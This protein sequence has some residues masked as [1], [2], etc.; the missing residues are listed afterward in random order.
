M[1]RIMKFATVS[2]AA[3]MAFASCDI[4]KHPVFDDKDAFVMITKSTISVEENANTVSIP[5]SMVAVNPVSVSVPY[6]IESGKAVEGVN[7]RLADPT[8][9]LTFDGKERSKDIVIEIID[10]AGSFD[11]DLDFTVVLGQPNGFNL[12]AQKTC[13]VTI[14]DLDHPLADILGTYT[15]SGFDGWDA[16]NVTWNMTINKVE[17]DVQAVS[18]NGLLGAIEGYSSGDQVGV[19]ND[20][21]DQI[22]IRLGGKFPWNSDYTGGI[23]GW[24]ESGNYGVSEGNL[25]LTYNKATKTWT[26]CEEDAEAQSLAIQLYNASDGSASDYWGAYIV[27][28]IT[29]TKQ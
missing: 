14:L 5:V 11:G 18:I 4:N 12:G 9:V 15:G 6:T 20:D 16:V 10:K 21:K 23:I 26:C 25:V 22:T 1:N 3:V 29:Y 2:V 24:N 28:P 13:K 27:G 7:Y 17:D 19:V 8:A